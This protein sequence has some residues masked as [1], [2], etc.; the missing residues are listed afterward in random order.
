MFGIFKKKKASGAPT[1]CIQVNG[2]DTYGFPTELYTHP[3][4]SWMGENYVDYVA[5][6]LIEQLRKQDAGTRLIAMKCEKPPELTTSL[7]GSAGHTNRVSLH[8]AL[9][10]L[11]QDTQATYWR[12]RGIAGFEYIDADDRAQQSVSVF[13][14]LQN[15]EEAT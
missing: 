8:I 2:I 10:L 13:F 12:L 1:E 11:V 3:L 6:A 5:Q 14:D 7:R 15:T 4:L 9:Q